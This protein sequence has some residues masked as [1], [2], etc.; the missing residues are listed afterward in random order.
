MRVSRWA[1]T[2]TGRTR[3]RPRRAELLGDV[4][5]DVDVEAGVLVALL[6]AEA[7][8]VEL[9]ADLDLL[10]GTAVGPRRPSRR[11][12]A[13][14]G[15]EARGP[16]GRGGGHG[17]DRRVVHVCFLLWLVD[18]EWCLSERC[19]WSV[20]EDLAEE[21]LGAIALGVGEELLGGGLSTIWPS[22]RKTTRWAALR[23][24][25]ISWVTTTMVMP[26]W[27]ADHDVEDLVDHLGVEGGGGLVEEHDLGVHRQGAG[28]RD[29]LLLATR[30]LGG[31]LGGL[32]GDADPLEQ[33]H[34]A[35]VGVALGVL[36]T[37]IGPSV[38]FSR[39]VLCAKRLKDWNTMP[40][41]ARRSASALPSSGSSLPSMVIEPDSMV[42]RRL[43]VRQSVDFPSPTGRS[44]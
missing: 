35:L 34:R 1:E 43:I 10:A 44:G 26:C 7:G 33:L 2:G 9:D 39:I 3:C 29:T 32:V 16:D 18:C 4:L 25:P 12:R 31:V 27:R 15:G 21:V 42:S 30:E 11:V 6:E 22:A 41:S 13:A 40:T 14:T 37:L 24:K 38:T 20:G 36:R 5:G 19:S 8:L 23:A 28:D 17:P